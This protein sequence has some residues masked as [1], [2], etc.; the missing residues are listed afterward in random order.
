MDWDAEYSSRPQ[1]WS[2]EPNATLVT[3][4]GS[5]TP[6]SALDV[7]CGEGADAIWLAR[8]GWHVTGIDV[9]QVALD[10]AAEAAAS[11]GVAIAWERRDIV[12]D[13][14]PAN[15]F[16]LVALHYLAL[17]TIPAD[18]AI[19]ALLGAVA[20]GGTLLVVGHDVVAGEHHHHGSELVQPRDVAA[21]L[22]DDW[23]VD[24]L[25]TRPR[26]PPPGFRGPD[27]PDVVLRAHRQAGTTGR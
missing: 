1:W 7:G 17:P 18:E 15:R 16:D 6:G 11:A 19:A 23:I 27:V 8:Q 10:R 12:A 4:V 21:R 13:P 9:S 20:P 22:T 2:G 14:P 24:V 26:T 5:L 3:E 25:E